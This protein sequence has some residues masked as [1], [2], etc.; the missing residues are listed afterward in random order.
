M[1]V[2]EDDGIGISDKIRPVL[3]ERGKGKNTGYGMFL[4]REI[5][6]I[7]GFTISETGEPGKG[8]RFEIVVPEGSFRMTD[9]K[10]QP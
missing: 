3:F 6:T 10:A 2:Y 5:L 9:K 8:V 7:T 4:I 1:I